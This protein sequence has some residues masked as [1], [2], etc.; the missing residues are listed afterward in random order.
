MPASSAARVADDAHPRKAA[1]AKAKSPTAAQLIERAVKSAEPQQHNDGDP[2]DAIAKSFSLTP[3]P[4]DLHGPGIRSQLLSSYIEWL[5]CERRCATSELWPDFNPPKDYEVI[6]ANTRWGRFHF[7]TRRWGDK[8]WN[9]RPHPLTRAALVLWAVGAI[10]DIPDPL[11]DL[12]TAYRYE[13]TRDLNHL[14]DEEADRHFDEVR[15]P[16]LDQIRAN[17][18][19][20]TTMHGAAEAIRFVLWDLKDNEPGET[21]SSVLNAVA[22][23]LEREGP[24]GPRNDE[25]FWIGGPR[26]DPLL[27]LL[28]RS[29]EA[30]RLAEAA[31]GDAAA[32][33]IYHPIHAEQANAPAATTMQGVM[34]GLAF[35]ING[36][37][38]WLDDCFGGVAKGALRGLETIVGAKLSDPVFRALE[39]HAEAFRAWDA[40]YGKVPD[41]DAKLK[42]ADD[43]EWKCWEDLLATSPKTLSGLA[44]LLDYYST[45]RFAQRIDEGDFALAILKALASISPI[46][47]GA[48]PSEN[49]GELGPAVLAFEAASRAF[50]ATPNDDADTTDIDSTEDE[51]RRL[52]QTEGL[53]AC[54][55]QEAEL[56]TRLSV[57]LSQGGECD[58]SISLAHA[59]LG[60]FL[61]EEAVS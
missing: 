33:A 5:D 27:D 36:D 53:N 46:L 28:A 38:A 40:L 57:R 42:A 17:T 1:R 45:P 3:D 58:L 39:A 43:R 35:G 55:L 13:M 49:G 32:N 41:S 34:T 12:L 8:T 56:A 25:V 60:Y 29:A 20:P 37:D 18:M 15:K 22:R 47:R 9:E 59:A 52:V 44:A 4:L 2:A 10:D 7:A 19:T 26:K 11:R 50:N 14:T 30:Y 48:A 31:E 23:F 6:P 21:T 51:L 54:S 24:T 16:L 61:G